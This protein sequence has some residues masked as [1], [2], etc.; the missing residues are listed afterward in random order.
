M[1]RTLELAE[2][3]VAN[4]RSNMVLLARALLADPASPCGRT[5]L[6]A[7]PRL[8]PHEQRAIV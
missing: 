3:I 1:I 7:N 6:G 5:A 4:G 8:I 2:E